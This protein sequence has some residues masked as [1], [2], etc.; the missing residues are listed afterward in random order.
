MEV[1]LSLSLF[2]A[3]VIGFK[4]AYFLGILME[5]ALTLGYLTLGFSLLASS[6][7]ATMKALP[8]VM[9]I[10]FT[11]S[12]IL[13]PASLPAGF[14]RAFP[15]LLAGLYGILWVTLGIATFRTARKGPDA[16]PANVGP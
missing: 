14:A 13:D 7:P 1:V 6:V 10:V 2:V 8:F 15:D 3:T 4:A 16:V 9:A 12:Y 11:P 5:P